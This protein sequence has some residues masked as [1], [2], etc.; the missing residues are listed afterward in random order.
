MKKVLIVSAHPDDDI[1][2]C[3]GIINRFHS[4]ARFKVIFIGEG[5]TCRFDSPDSPEA[6]RALV[7]RTH[8]A[9]QS[10]D[11]LGISDYKFY[12]LPCGRLD[13]EP[14]IKINKIIEKEIK[15]FEPDTIFTHSN[16]DSNKDHSKVY[17]STI[18]A[19]RPQ[20]SVKDLYSYEVL[21]SSEWGFHKAFSPSVFYELSEKDVLVKWGALKKYSAEIEE[22]PHPRSKR[23]VFS[24]ASLRGM[25]SGF[26]YAEAFRLVRSFR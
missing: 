23:G 9:K 12:D 1:L 2:G 26:E 18:I 22:W 13:Q 6:Q 19:T 8:C 24:L 4:Q 7:T 11:F 17:D 14:Q 20:C 16:L 25:Q 21:S 10:L 15:S 3:G 5:S